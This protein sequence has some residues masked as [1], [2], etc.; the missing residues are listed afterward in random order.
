MAGII[1]IRGV[2]DQLHRRLTARAGSNNR[3]VAEEVLAILED[4]LSE[5]A[6]SA[7]NEETD[8]ARQKRNDARRRAMIDWALR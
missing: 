8:Q 3:T 4:V 2:P 6:A 7:P 5:P 1:Q